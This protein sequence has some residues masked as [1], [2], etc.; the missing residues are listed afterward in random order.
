MT[1]GEKKRN[2]PTNKKK[3]IEQITPKPIKYQCAK[4][5]DASI[6]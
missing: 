2:K 4:N 3:K 1:C 6:M 5:D